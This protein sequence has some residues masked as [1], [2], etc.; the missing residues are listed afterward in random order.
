MRLLASYTKTVEKLVLWQ[1]STVCVC[2][3][4][5]PGKDYYQMIK[6]PLLVSGAFTINSPERLYQYCCVKTAIILVL[7]I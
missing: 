7:K 5:F 1:L 2:E 3:Q 4:N 6:M